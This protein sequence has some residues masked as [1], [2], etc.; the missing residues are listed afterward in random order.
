MKKIIILPII[1]GTLLVVGGAIA[2]GFAYMNNKDE[3]EE[4]TYELT[5]DFEKFN[6][7]LST[8]DLS[9]K[10]S[11]GGAKRVVVKERKKEYHTVEVKDGTLSIQI[12]DEVKWYEKIFR[13]HFNSMKV[14]VYLPEGEYNDLTI[15]TATGD[16]YVPAAFS[17]NSA[18]VKAST[19]NI[20][21]G[22]TVTNNMR[23]TASTGNV[24]YHDA[25][26]K[27][28][29]IKTSTGNIT[30]K[31]VA[32][33]D[34]VTLN[35]STGRI[36][37][38]NLTCVNMNAETDTGDVSL[39]NV[40]VNS[41]IEI[42]TDTGD[43]TFSD[44]DAQSVKVKTS[45]GDVDATFLTKKIITAKS[46]TGRIRTPSADEMVGATG[47]CEVKTSTGSINIKIKA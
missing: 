31:D 9:F 12:V 11:E 40:L 35:A 3:I 27:N 23:L 13:F 44:S 2:I 39:T 16:V 34:Q 29:N 47:T 32:I 17:F 4:K 18:E 25:T 6:I 38:E 10:K 37:T 19:G 21:V 26:A 42:H 7:N 43:V 33:N 36:K 8:A 30:V 5:D 41:N 15:K 22:S 24:H 46:S 14:E 45:T 1:L 20:E 28:L